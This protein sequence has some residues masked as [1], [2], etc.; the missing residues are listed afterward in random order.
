MAAAAA[1]CQSRHNPCGTREYTTS[2]ASTCGRRGTARK[3]MKD[4]PDCW[5]CSP[6]DWTTT[7]GGARA[8]PALLAKHHPALHPFTRLGQGGSRQAAVLRCDVLTWQ[9]RQVVGS[10]GSRPRKLAASSAHRLASRAAGEGRCGW[11]ACRQ[12]QRAAGPRARPLNNCTLQQAHSQPLGRW[13]WDVVCWL[14][15][16]PAGHALKRHTAHSCAAAAPLQQPGLPAA[17]GGRR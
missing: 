16:Y 10:C 17:A 13:P 9:K 2:R 7:L 5:T 4:L 15:L 8:I 14:A 3:Q 11:M 12:G 1:A 6:E